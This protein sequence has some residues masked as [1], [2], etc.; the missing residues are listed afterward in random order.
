MPKERDR[1]PV[2]DEA[3]RLFDEGKYKEAIKLYDTLIVEK[4]VGAEPFFMKAECLFNLKRYGDS[5]SWYD[6]AIDIDD[7]DALF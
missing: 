4:K 3:N 7:E 1:D 5:I 6:K 2:F